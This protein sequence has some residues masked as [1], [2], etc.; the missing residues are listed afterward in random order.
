MNV[1]Q[2]T[3]HNLNGNVNIYLMLLVLSVLFLRLLLALILIH[4]NDLGFG[5]YLIGH[6][7]RQWQ[8]ASLYITQYGSG[9]QLVEVAKNSDSSWQAL[10]FPAMVGV[11]HA[12]VGVGYENVLVVKFSLLILALYSINWL[13]RRESTNFR[14]WIM[15]SYLLY[16]PLNAL[17][18]TYLRDDYLVNLVFLFCALLDRLL[19]T[20]SLW[21]VFPIFLVSQQL[22]FTRVSSFFLACI[23]YGFFFSSISIYELVKRRWGLL[24]TLLAI[25]YVLVSTIAIDFFPQIFDFVMT[26]AKLDMTIIPLSIKWYFGPLPWNMVYVVSEYSP[27][28][29]VLSL[30]TLLTLLVNKHTI[31]RARDYFPAL[32]LMWVF[33]FLPYYFVHW[34]VNV[35]GPRQFAMV[36]YFHFLIMFSWIFKSGP[37]KKFK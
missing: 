2:K 36:G 23:L 9:S 10:G 20:R 19:V 33:V 24:V 32:F 27:H 8:E 22:I 5:V 1:I 25:A 21:L 18:A 34:Y 7:E 11:L 17:D 12:I 29:Y 28:W 14:L 31:K 4:A 15:L 35:I 6:D 13:F 26:R 3:T 30:A 16:R 37:D